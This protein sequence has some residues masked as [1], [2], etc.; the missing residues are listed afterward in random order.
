[1]LKPPNL[2]D[3]YKQKGQ[4][5]KLAE[6]LKNEGIRNERVLAAIA[7][8]PRHQFVKYA[9]QER[10]YENTALRIDEDQTI[11]QPYTVAFQTECL[12]IKSGDKV[13]EIGTGSGY[14][15]VVLAELGARVFTIERIH[16][17]HLKSKLQ[18]VSLGYF[19]I[20]SKFGD[21]FLGWESEGPFDKILITAAPEAIP[22]KL[23]LQ[24]KIGGQMIV[25][26][27]GQ[28]ES[29]EMM[30]ITRKDEEEYTVEQKGGFRFVPMMSERETTSRYR[31]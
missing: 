21:G 1:M 28:H 19:T 29:Q 30:L 14:Q 31:H 7:K 26:V 23:K 12:G 16:K 20:Q 17:L 25:P 22:E 24:L 9:L 27:G 3:T 18:F 5:R 4:R 2:K 6:A 15:A 13:L 8:I 10:A 11:S